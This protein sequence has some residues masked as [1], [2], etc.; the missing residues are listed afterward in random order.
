MKDLEPPAYFFTRQRLLWH[1]VTDA[2]RVD[3]K[4]ASAD[5]YWLRACL[6]R[7]MYSQYHHDGSGERYFSSVRVPR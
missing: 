7:T 1:Y 4:Y 2:M 6:M 3:E 5:V